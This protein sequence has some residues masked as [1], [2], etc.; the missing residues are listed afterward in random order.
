M[1]SIGNHLKLSVPRH[2]RERV[3]A[4]YVDVLQCSTMPSPAADLDLF[5]FSNSFVLGV[6]F[7][8]VAEVLSESDHLK[9][10]WLEIKTTDVETIKRRL[11]ELGVQEVDYPDPTRFYFRAPGGQ[12]FRLA[13]EDGG[14]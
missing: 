4:F 11:I 13:P 12:V 5:L 8:D 7:C 14:I 10:A 2:L 9:A 6:F 3:R 1:T